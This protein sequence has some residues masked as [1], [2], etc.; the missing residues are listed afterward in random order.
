[1]IIFLET[2]GINIC[3]INI[4]VITLYTHYKLPDLK[5]SAVQPTSHSLVYPVY[6][7]SFKGTVIRNLNLQRTTSQGC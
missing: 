4:N 1:M 5:G 2:Q 7:S 6:N 3:N